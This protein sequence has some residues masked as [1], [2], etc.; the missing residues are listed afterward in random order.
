LLEHVVHAGEGQAGVPGLLKLA[1]G[2]ELFGEAT[3][4]G[5]LAYVGGRKRKCAEAASLV[6]ARVVAER[7]K[8]PSDG[9]VS[10]HSRPAVCGRLALRQRSIHRAG[11]GT[12][13]IETAAYGEV[14]WPER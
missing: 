14:S 9:W 10:F 6:V 11:R 8:L 4:T 2:V 1:V 13:S 12:L 3:Y 7:Q 5:L